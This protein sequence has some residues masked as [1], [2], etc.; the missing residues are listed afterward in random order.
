M[1]WPRPKTDYRLSSSLKTDTTGLHLAQH[2]LHTCY[3]NVFVCFI[4]F[5]C[6]LFSRELVYMREVPYPLYRVT[7]VELHTPEFEF[8][9]AADFSHE[10]DHTSFA[11]GYCRGD[12]TRLLRLCNAASFSHS[13]HKLH[14]K[15]STIMVTWRRNGL[16]EYL[17]R[18]RNT[19]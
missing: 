16:Q 14:A 17:G 9:S 18:Y 2:H 15:L 12:P 4:G 6:F 1:E 8:C 7:L 13:I 3:S 5:W 10:G 19:C 11:S